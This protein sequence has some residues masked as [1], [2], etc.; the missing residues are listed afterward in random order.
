MIGIAMSLISKYSS[1]FRIS[2]IVNV[3]AAP[4]SI[5]GVSITNGFIGMKPMAKSIAN[6]ESAIRRDGK[7]SLACS[8]ML[9]LRKR[10]E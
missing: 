3:K 6:I 8:Q 2:Q 5:W 9:Y 10:P 4:T 7:T 1:G